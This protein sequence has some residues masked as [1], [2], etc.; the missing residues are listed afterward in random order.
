MVC[1]RPLNGIR[2]TM[3]KIWF[4]IKH[5]ILLRL[6]L[7]IYSN[8]RFCEKEIDGIKYTLDLYSHCGK[9]L[10]FD[11]VYEKTTTNII[12][13]LVKERMV[14]FDIG[15]SNGVFSLQMSKIVGDDGQ[16]FAFEPSSRLFPILQ[17]HIKINNFTNITAEKIALTDKDGIEPIISQRLASFH[18]K[19]PVIEQ[20]EVKCM[21]ID[22]YVKEKKLKRIDFFKIDTDGKE[23]NIIKGAKDV[24]QKYCPIMIIE[25]SKNTN[26]SGLV[27]LLLSHGY[28]FFY[29]D[30][31]KISY[32]PEDIIKDAEDK[33]FNV[34]C[35]VGGGK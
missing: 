25:F 19:I 23:Y 17:N 13:R 5:S 30:N 18:D 31:I 28:T 2:F 27:N 21:T 16:V 9:Q 10:Y 4:A 29:E 35:K 8:K 6:Y 11:G 15:A 12:S 26:V 34:L 20:E 22:S 24:L 33:I 1:G 7:R 14:V 32:K 3:N